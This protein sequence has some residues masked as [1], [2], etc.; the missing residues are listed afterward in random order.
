MARFTI[1][2]TIYVDWEFPDLETAVSFC[3][4]VTTFDLLDMDSGAT[5]SGITIKD[6]A[7]QDILATDL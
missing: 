3:S 1:E 6:A 4:N 2:Q 5:T 7:T